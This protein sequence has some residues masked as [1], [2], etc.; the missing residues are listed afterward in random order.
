MNKHEAA[1]KI[2]DL[3][4]ACDNKLA[5]LNACVIWGIDIPYAYENS[6]VNIP[7]H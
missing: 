5:C 7:I 3:M 2:E 6:F 1:G 4:I